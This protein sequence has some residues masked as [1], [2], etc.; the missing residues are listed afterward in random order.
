MVAITGATGL[1]GGHILDK[2]LAE[3]VSPIALCRPGQDSSLPEG[4]HKRTG[5]ILDQ[6]SLREAL[7]GATTVIHGAAFVSFNP[8]R[9]KKIFEVNVTGTRNVVDTCLQLGVKNFI[10][11]SS[12]SALG[13][14]PGEEISEESKWN[15][16]YSSDY[17]ESKYL[18]ELEVFR[19]AEEGLTVS[20]LNPS[21]ILSTAQPNRSSGTLFNYSWNEIPFY[22]GGSLNYVDARDVAEATYQLYIKPRAGE[23]FILNAGNLLYHDFFQ[24]VAK[25]LNKRSP[26]IKISPFFS[27]WAGW[28]EEVRSLIVHREPLVTRQSARMAIQSFHY[29]NKKAQTDLGIRFRPLEETLDWCCSQYLGNVK[30]NK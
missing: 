19:A 24:K 29:N 6:V 8:R 26:S 25:R 13:R 12:V 15:G 9:R 5:D 7:D 27:S 14:K 21:T 4:I 20:V 16:G 3:A 23:K 10:H 28:A 11:I 30:P 1:L 18:A 17:A 22:T 2:L